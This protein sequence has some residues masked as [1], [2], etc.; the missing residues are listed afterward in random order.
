MDTV[1]KKQFQNPSS[2]YRTAPLWVWNDIMDT[3]EIRK[4]LQG[5]KSHG[6]GGAFVH[7]RPGLVTEYLSE[8]WFDRWRDALE[9]AKKLDM[10]LYIYDEYSYPSGFA[11]GHVPSQLPDCLGNAIVF[12]KMDAADLEKERGNASPMLNR[13]GYPVKA[14]A[15]E[16]GP[17]GQYRITHDLTQI[18][19]QEWPKYGN[20]FLVF[21]FGREETNAWLGGFSYVD[22]MRPEVTQTFLA[23]TY[24]AYKAR[25]GDSFGRD[26]PAVFTDEPYVAAGGVYH[27]DWRL[28]CR[29][30]LV[31]QIFGLLLGS[32]L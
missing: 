24:E 27:S 21:E 30:F 3:Q 26:I 22:L 32:N 11:G 10:K 8:E 31:I 16:E 23:V 5:L 28:P 2:I 25:F 29:F 9:E 15:Y 6:F 1:D 20:L 4:Q 19:S 12:R 7:P 14:F 18:P 17:S 13:P